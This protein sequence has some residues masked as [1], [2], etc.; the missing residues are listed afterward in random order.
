MATINEL[1]QFI[2]DAPPAAD[3]YSPGYVGCEVSDGKVCK[4]CAS[5]IMAR[6]FGSAFRDARALWWD[7]PD[8]RS[9]DIC[10]LC[11]QVLN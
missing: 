1:R 8:L 7:S 4:R 11:F 10:G 3:T 5:R 9:N 6:G 2:D